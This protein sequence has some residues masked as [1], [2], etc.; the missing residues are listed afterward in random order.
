MSR[1][2]CPA[3]NKET[4]TFKQKLLAGKWVDIYCSNCGARFCDL[5]IALA[6]MH[7]A[8]TW[9]ILFFGYMAVRESSIAYAIAM[10]VG[11]LLLE[12]FIYYLPLTRLRLKQPPA[13]KSTD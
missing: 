4:I 1:I 7:F 5:P 3:C 9:D 11:W 12:F 2:E 10:I 13:E 8:I 6:L